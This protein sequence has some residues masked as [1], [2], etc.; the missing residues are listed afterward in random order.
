MSSQEAIQLSNDD[1]ILTITLNRPERLNAYNGAMQR[2]L[3]ETFDFVHVHVK[4]TDE[5]GHSKRPRHKRDVIAATDEGLEELLTLSKRA[6]VAVTGDHATP[7]VSSLLHSGDPTPFIVAGPGVAADHVTQFGETHCQ[8]GT[9]G[10]LA[11]SDIMPVLVGFA[12]RPFF[13][14][15]RPGDTATIA[16]PNDPEPMP[17]D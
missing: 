1:G 9:C 2:E 13:R 4:A 11:A 12:N 17:P 5:A 15:H 10:R 6:I 16:L 8:Q 14:G 3:I 7:S